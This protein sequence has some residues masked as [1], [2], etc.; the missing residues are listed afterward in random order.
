VSKK[1]LN[2][3]LADDNYATIIATVEEGRTIFSKYSKVPAVF[4]LVEYR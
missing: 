1:I 4:A 2:V 3:V